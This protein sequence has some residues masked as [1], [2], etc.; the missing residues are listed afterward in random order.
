MKRVTL[1]SC[2]GLLF[3]ASACLA[4]IDLPTGFDIDFQLAAKARATIQSSIAVNSDAASQTGMEVF[5]SLVGTQ[6]ISGFGLPYR[7]SFEVV[8]SSSVNAFSL[9]D[10]E[11]GSTTALARLVGT[12]RGLW[13][14]VLSHE[15]AHTARRHWVTKYLYED[16]LQRQIQYWQARARYGDK[17]ANWVLLGLRISGPIAY[18]KLSRN[19]ENDA[20]VQ[21]MLLMARAGYHPDYV[22]AMHHLL[23]LQVGEQSKFGAFFS[24]H[25]RWETRDQR[26]EKAYADALAE[27]MRLWQV[28]PHHRAADHHWLHLSVRRTAPRTKKQEGLT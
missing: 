25:P 22:F 6:M 16:M 24:D 5:R 13:A 14:A 7:W 10:G 21:G 1:L 8:N 18:K 2:L 27:Y 9:P 20:D 4:Q 3:G 11:T 15:I 17:S 12:N 19:L 28:L 26:T 23:R